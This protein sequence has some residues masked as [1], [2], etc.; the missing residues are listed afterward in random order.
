M[1]VSFCS[2]VGLLSRSKKIWCCGENVR[3]FSGN[4]ETEETEDKEEKTDE[5]EKF[6]RTKSIKV[7]L[8]ISF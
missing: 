5:K 3:F 7:Y 4:E 6:A 1:L 2:R 8:F